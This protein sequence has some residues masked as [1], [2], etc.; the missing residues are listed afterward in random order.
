LGISEREPSAEDLVWVDIT[1]GWEDILDMVTA[2][3][4]YLAQSCQINCVGF[5]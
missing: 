4:Q 2:D 3:T 1:W 5:I